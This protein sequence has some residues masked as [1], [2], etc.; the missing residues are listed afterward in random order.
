[1][2][3]CNLIHNDLSTLDARKL[4][5][6][7]VVSR[8]C[9]ICTHFCLLYS[10]T[11]CP[12]GHTVSLALVLIMSLL[13]PCYNSLRKKLEF[14]S[15]I[16]LKLPFTSWIYDVL[17]NAFSCV[18]LLP[19]KFLPF[20]WLRA[21]VLQLNLKYLHVKIT[22]TMVTQNHQIISSHEL[23][24]NGGR[25]SRFWNQEIQE[26]KENSENQNTE[27]STSTWLNLDQL[28]RK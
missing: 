22:V 4:R 24:K 14:I 12:Y 25:I 5:L 16:E 8:P 26:L 23:R 11:I 15:V 17:R 28:S 21:E 20:D 18:I 10:N 27:E 6:T 9:L 3:T 2:R 7:V 13:Q 1:M 19:E